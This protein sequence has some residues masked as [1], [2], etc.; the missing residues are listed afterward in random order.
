MTSTVDRRH[1][2]RSPCSS[3][4]SATSTPPRRTSSRRS[5]RRHARCRR[6]CRRRRRFRKVNPADA[7]ILYIVLS[8]TTLPLSTVDDY[9]ENL[10]AQQISTISG[11]AQVAST[12]RR[13]TRCASSSIPNALAARG[14]GIDQ[15]SSGRR[16]RQ[17]QPADRNAVRPRPGDLGQ[18]T[19]QLDER[20]RLRA[21]DRRLSQRRAG[22]PERDRTRIRQRA[23]RQD[24]CLVQRHARQ[25]CS[26]SSGSRAPT[27]SRSSTRSRRSCRRSRRSC[28]RR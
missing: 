5:P 27:P 22:A 26:R 2:R 21:D 18:A 24:R 14:I 16:Q 20:G 15:T 19:G 1:R 7:P 13:S 9:A 8:S 4:S 11:V 6:R 3:R 12:A 10:L 25:S 23:E 17:R 28:R